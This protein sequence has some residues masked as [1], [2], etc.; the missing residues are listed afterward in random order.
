MN[1]RTDDDTTNLREYYSRVED[2]LQHAANAEQRL[3]QVHQVINDTNHHLDRLRLAERRLH[4]ARMLGDESSSA[5]EHELMVALMYE[6]V[7]HVY[8]SLHLMDLD[9]MALNATPHG[10]GL[11][12]DSALDVIHTFRN[13]ETI[14]AHILSRAGQL[15]IP[16]DFLH[17]VDEKEGLSY[18]RLA[19]WQDF[20]PGSVKESF[21][22]Y[23]QRAGRATID[24]LAQRPNFWERQNIEEY[25]QTRGCQSLLTLTRQIEQ[26]VPLQERID[27]GRAADES[28]TEEHGTLWQALHWRS[29]AASVVTKQ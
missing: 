11:I 16:L 1:Q 18:G 21:H 7:D 13:L 26:I 23:F 27:A 2:R 25:L 20:V 3:T 22:R 15:G 17:A 19:H 12:G 4:R 5:Y 6:A 24:R 29:K 8:I 28:E 10:Y 9:L 14:S